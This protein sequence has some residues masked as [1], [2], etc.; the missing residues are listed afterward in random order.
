[1]S[2]SGQA[3]L[4]VVKETRSSLHHDAYSNM[5]CPKMAPSNE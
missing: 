4:A 1:M 3:L 5:A 2:F